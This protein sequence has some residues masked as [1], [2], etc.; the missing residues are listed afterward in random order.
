MRQWLKSVDQIGHLIN[1]LV[2][3]C[4]KYANFSH[5]TEEEKKNETSVV[6]FPRTLNN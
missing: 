2:D 1:I 4:F 3:D 6:F 5:Y